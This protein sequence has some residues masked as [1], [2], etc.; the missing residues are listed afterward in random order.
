[1]LGSEAAGEPGDGSVAVVGAVLGPQL[2]G[3]MQGPPV[4]KLLGQVAAAAAAA[5]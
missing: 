2:H 4:A 5:A 1:M 3:T